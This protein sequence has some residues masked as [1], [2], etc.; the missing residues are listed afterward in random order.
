M[1]I[2]GEAWA[3]FLFDAEDDRCKL[4]VGDPSPTN[5]ERE[6]K[7]IM[8]AV[9]DGLVHMAVTLDDNTTEHRTVVNEKVGIEWSAKPD[10]QSGTEW[11]MWVAEAVARH[12]KLPMDGF[13]RLQQKW[14][15]GLQKTVRGDVPA[16]PTQKQPVSSV[17]LPVDTDA[18]GPPGLDCTAAAPVHPPEE[19]VK[20]AIA[21]RGIADKFDAAGNRIVTVIGNETLGVEIRMA[22]AVTIGNKRCLVEAVEF[23][24][25]QGQEVLY[26]RVQK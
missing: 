14:V 15:K 21:V 4:C 12:A 23:G 11:N 9:E 18:G 16:A 24:E 22:G 19:T 13:P 1:R 25:E 3:V 7:G 17:P 20:Q 5:P 8:V 2:H 6:V 10:V 26:L